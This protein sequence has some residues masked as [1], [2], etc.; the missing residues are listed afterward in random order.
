M[1]RTRR[2]QRAMPSEMNLTPLLDVIFNLLFFFTIATTLKTNE[3]HL[4]LS[5][6][7]SSTAEV[8]KDPPKLPRI[9]LF[10]DGTMM[11]DGIVLSAPVLQETL[12]AR[13]ERDGVTE[14][15]LESDG[16]ATMQQLIT[17]TDLCRSAGI[18]Q[19]SPRVVQRTAATP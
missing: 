16:Q 1:S 14:V 5:L 3:F 2:R 15:I 4:Q 11:L 9:Q 7:S 19:V 18:R 10:E 17:V 13:K 8:V 12:A 6:P